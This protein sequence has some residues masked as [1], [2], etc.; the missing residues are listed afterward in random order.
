MNIVRFIVCG[1]FF[2]LAMIGDKKEHKIK[3]KLVLVFLC[4]GIIINV[5]TFD[6]R[7]MLSSLGTML[8]P[9]LLLPLFAVRALGAGDIKALC[10][11]GLIMGIEHGINVMAYSFVGAGIIALTLMILRKNMLE[12]FKSFFDYLRISFMKGNFGRYETFDSSNKFFLF[13]Y[14]LITGWT[15]AFIEYLMSI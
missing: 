6:Y 11:A 14:G 8:I 13:T 3:N 12:R 4:I 1:V 5:V 15:M 2:V 9:L 10:T 7:I